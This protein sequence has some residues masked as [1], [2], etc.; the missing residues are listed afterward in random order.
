VDTATPRMQA[1][2]LGMAERM[3][4]DE[5]SAEAAVFAEGSGLDLARAEAAQEALGAAPFT[6]HGV[7][8]MPRPTAHYTAVPMG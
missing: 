4:L 6:R 1:T 3:A 7:Q 2:G 5:A 8:D